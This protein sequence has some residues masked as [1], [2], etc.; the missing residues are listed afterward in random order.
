MTSRLKRIKRDVVFPFEV[1]NAR[2]CDYGGM[3]VK[4][5][6]P[7]GDNIKIKGKITGSWMSMK[8]RFYWKNGKRFL[9]RNFK[10]FNEQRLIG[11]KVRVKEM[12]AKYTEQIIIEQSR[13]IKGGK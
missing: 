5:S 11:C 6:Q 7:H 2:H 1:L 10:K 9:I 13:I 3:D 4:V 8:G 12:E